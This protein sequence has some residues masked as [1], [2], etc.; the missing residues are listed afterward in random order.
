M[1]CEQ[2]LTRDSRTELNGIPSG[3]C[4]HVKSFGKVVDITNYIAERGRAES[5]EMSI[6]WSSILAL[7]EKGHLLVWLTGLKRAT[8]ER[9]TEEQWREEE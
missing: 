5:R 1:I 7:Q 8:G 2:E 9:Q 4:D 3:V 6:G